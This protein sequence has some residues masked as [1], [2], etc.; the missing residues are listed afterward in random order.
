MKLSC[1]LLL[2]LA[3]L[4]EACTGSV[5]MG[6]DAVAIYATKPASPPAA[7]TQD[8]IAEHE[9]W[10]Y[11][12]MGD[13]Q[14]YPRAQDVSPGRLINVD[15]PSRYPLDTVAYRQAVNEKKAAV[16]A[17]TALVPVPDIEA[18]K[19]TLKEELGAAEL[20]PTPLLL[21]K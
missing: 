9:S 11:S 12:T 19:K 10:C 4:L 6:A 1:A 20:K 13:V 8:Q 17:P 7:N 21:P 3:P 14:C 5:I 2:M 15:P 18:E 16:R